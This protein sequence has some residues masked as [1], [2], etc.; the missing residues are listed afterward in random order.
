MVTE[1]GLD[2]QHPVNALYINTKGLFGPQPLVVTDKEVVNIP[3]HLLDMFKEIL[4]DK[5]SI[6]AVNDSVVAFKIY[7]YNNTKGIQYSISWADVLEQTDEPFLT[8]EPDLKTIKKRKKK[9]TS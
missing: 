2:V 9:Y 1:Y 8:E 5:E 3:A 7:E 4:Q 6:K